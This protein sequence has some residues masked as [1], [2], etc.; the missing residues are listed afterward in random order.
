MKLKS[1]YNAQLREPRPSMP[2]CSRG[3]K[4]VSLPSN[5]FSKVYIS[6]AKKRTWQKC[7]QR[8]LL[9]KGIYTSL[10]SAINLIAK[11]CCKR[12]K[13]WLA[14]ASFFLYNSNNVNILVQTSAHGVCVWFCRQGSAFPAAGQ[15]GL[16]A[17]EGH[18]QWLLGLCPEHCSDPSGSFQ[19]AGSGPAQLLMQQIHHRMEFVHARDIKIVLLHHCLCWTFNP[20]LRG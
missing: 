12:V 5:L 19:A 10:K 15:D 18:R 8:T 16:E 1:I 14:S 7:I 2:C 4:V 11:L 6:A 17:E 20:S 3:F 9:R 13:T